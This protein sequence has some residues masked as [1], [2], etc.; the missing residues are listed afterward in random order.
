MDLQKQ[1]VIKFLKIMGQELCPE[2]RKELAEAFGLSPDE[3]NSIPNLNGVTFQE[4]GNGC[5]EYQKQLFGTS[6]R[7]QS[8]AEKM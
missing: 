1:A 6:E 3:Y 5:H 4:F 2:N 8:L 7:E